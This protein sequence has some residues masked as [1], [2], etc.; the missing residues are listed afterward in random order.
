MVLATSRSCNKH[1]TRYP[2]FYVEM[3]AA[4]WGINKL[5]PY[6]YG[7]HF[8]LITDHRPITYLMNKL[9]GLSDMHQRW[10]MQLQEYSFNVIHRA[11][12]SHQI[13]DVPSRHPLPSHWDSTGACLNPLSA[14]EQMEAT[15]GARDSM[16]QDNAGIVAATQ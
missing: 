7:M 9:D 1:E 12:K 10:Q 6:I 11:G 14:E 8:T 13:A 4:T 3:L 5:R 2:P 16:V 15:V